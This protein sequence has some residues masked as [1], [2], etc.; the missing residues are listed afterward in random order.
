MNKMACKAPVV[1]RNPYYIGN[2][3]DELTHQEIPCGQCMSCLQSKS[4][5]WIFRI[6]QEAKTAS[7]AFF[8]TFTLSDENLVLTESGQQTLD[9]RHMQLY[10]K[11]LRKAHSEKIKYFTVGEYGTKTKR[12]HYHSIIF[13]AR[14]DLIE[15]N[16]KLGIAHVGDVTQD[17]I[18]YVTKYMMKMNKEWIKQNVENGIQKEFALISKG[19][20]LSYLQ[21][22]EVVK[23]HTG[24]LRNSYLSDTTGYRYAMPRYYREKMYSEEQRAELRRITRARFD[25]KAR[26]NDTTIRSQEEQGLQPYK[27]EIDAR[28]YQEWLAQKRINQTINKL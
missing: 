12:P 19:L 13:N 24:D 18:A 26:E 4:R 20:G 11:S 21:N 23:Y 16:W 15:S 8:S 7:C 28:E 9:K 1:I 22:P 6:Q 5:E 25:A 10:F 2:P 17:S 27:E 3:I 14:K